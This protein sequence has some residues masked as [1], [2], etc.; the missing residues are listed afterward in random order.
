MLKKLRLKFILM[1][2]ISV[3]FVLAV[4]I[5]AINISNYAVIEHNASNTLVEIVDFGLKEQ[6]PPEQRKPG[7]DNRKEESFKQSQYFITVFGQDGSIKESNYSRMFMLSDEECKDLSLKVYNNEL[8]G[9]KY[10]SYR[11]LKK[12]KDDE[13]TVAED[14]LCG[15]CLREVTPDLRR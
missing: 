12:V 8:K 13:T 5:G 1:S 4:T 14:S 11:F 9:R 6:L 3:F 7:E 10:E 2:M 15:L